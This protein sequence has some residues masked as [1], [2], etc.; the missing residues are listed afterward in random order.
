MLHIADAEDGWLRYAVTK[1][2]EDWPTH[3][4]LVNYPSK[5]SILTALAEVHS[6]MSDY[7]SK[8]SETGLLSEITA[9]WGE[10]IPLLWVL[11][12][13]IEHEIHHRGELSFSLGIL[14]REGGIQ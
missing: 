1:E 14:G 5:E 3:Y 2:L 9:P 6:R 8:L 7:I 4:S 13:V 10:E 11:W 12:H